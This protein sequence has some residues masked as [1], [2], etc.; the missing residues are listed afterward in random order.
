MHPRAPH[1]AVL[2]DTLSAQLFVVA[3]HAHVS[4]SLTS[5]VGVTADV[6]LPVAEKRHLNVGDV[7]QG[8]DKDCAPSSLPPACRI[9]FLKRT[10]KSIWRDVIRKVPIFFSDVIDRPCACLRRGSGGH[11]RRL[12]AA[13]ARVF[14]QCTSGRLSQLLTLTK[15]AREVVL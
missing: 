13:G 5:T 15:G 10:L 4:C 2:T 1:L 6:V 11:P 8:F 3:L 9:R 14:L 7:A 12:A